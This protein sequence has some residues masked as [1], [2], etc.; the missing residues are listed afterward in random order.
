ME[1]LEGRF[2]LAQQL[3]QQ[4]GTLLAENLSGDFAVSKKGAINLV[5]EMDLRAEKLI[6][7]GI[8]SRFPN[9]AILSEEEGKREGDAGRRWIIDPLDGTTNYAHG[10]RLFCVSIAFELDGEVVLGVVHDPMADETF[11]A[12]KGQG[13]FLNGVPMRVSEQDSLM[14]SLLCTGF[15]YEMDAIREGLELFSRVLL[16]SRAVR[17]DG[18][19]A[20]DLCFVAAGRFEGFWEKGLNSWDVAAGQLIVSQAGGRVTDFQDGP[21]QLEGRQIVAT[22]GGIH[23]A[24][25]EA[26]SGSGGC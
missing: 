9:D 6:L 17:R 8:H 15:P 5:T 14:D 21:I 25:L 4:A 12:R 19:A 2:E 10:Y 24:L 20:L 1:G 22:N 11:K 7:Q 23:Q 18:S 26:I 16:Q 13:A 3:A